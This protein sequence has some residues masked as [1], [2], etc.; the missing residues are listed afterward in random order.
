MWAKGCGVSEDALRW[1]WRELLEAVERVKLFALNLVY[2][3][4]Y[5]TDVCIILYEV[6]T[7]E[8]MLHGWKEVYFLAA[9]PGSGVQY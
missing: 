6:K 8:A 9:S 2:M 4:R 1:G 5:L 7:E 3:P